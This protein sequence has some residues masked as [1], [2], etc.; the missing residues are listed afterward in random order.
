N[1]DNYLNFS[2]DLIFNHNPGVEDYLQGVLE[3]RDLKISGKMGIVWVNNNASAFEGTWHCAPKKITVQGAIEEKDSRPTKLDG[4]FSVECLKA[5]TFDPEQPMSTS[6]WLHP[7]VGFEGLIQAYNGDKLFQGQ[8]GLYLE[9]LAYQ[10][11]YK[12][13]GVYKLTNAGVARNLSF[14]LEN[15]DAR[16]LH[17]EIDSTWGPAEIVM[18]AIFT[19]DIQTA[20]EKHLPPSVVTGS[21]YVE[22]T[23]VGTIRVTET[24][25]I[26]VDYNDGT[27]EEF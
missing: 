1:T 22:G 16:T 21:V 8:A 10:E 2:G 12:I 13:S 11:R 17:V 14:S 19:P 5:D 25:I 3:C 7:K 24:G 20:F 18:D 6:N 15:T 26:R 27:Y 9:E 23:E 4:T